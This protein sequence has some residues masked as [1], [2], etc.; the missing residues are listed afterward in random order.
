MKVK[1]ENE[2]DALYPEM[3]NLKMILMLLL[4]LIGMGCRGLNDCQYR[5]RSIR[6]PNTMSM[7]G[8]RA[9]ILVF[10]LR[11]LHHHRFHE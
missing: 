4:G 8:T 5:L 7:H 11:R 3:E 10:T 1:M 6:T 9:V 2:M